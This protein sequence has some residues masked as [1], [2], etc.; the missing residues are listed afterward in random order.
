MRASM[1]WKFGDISKLLL[2]TIKKEYV[3]AKVADRLNS[4]IDMLREELLKTQYVVDNLME[5]VN[6]LSAKHEGA[7]K[8][9]EQRALETRSL[10]DL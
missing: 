10:T 2:A 3:S 7:A 4:D 1:V 9:S 5:R 6:A 8:S